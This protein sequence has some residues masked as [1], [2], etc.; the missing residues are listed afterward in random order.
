M[1]AEIM[2]ELQP[3][4]MPIVAR[5]P[6][7]LTIAD[8]DLQQSLTLRLHKLYG[9]LMRLTQSGVKSAQHPHHASEISQAAI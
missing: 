3:H 5:C 1:L 4:R 7:L 8:E 2:K 6:K 9:D